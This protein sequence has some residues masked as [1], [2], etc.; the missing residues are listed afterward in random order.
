MRRQ[1]GAG[2]NQLEYRL[3][4]VVALTGFSKQVLH[5]WEHRYPAMSPQR[6]RISP[7]RYSDTEVHRLQLLKTCIEGGYKIGQLAALEVNELKR[8]SRAC[9]PAVQVP[10]DELLHA[11]QSMDAGFL[12]TRLA[13]LFATLG[14]VRFA[15]TVVDPLMTEVGA[16]WNSGELTIAAEHCVTAIVRNVLGQALRQ[17]STSPSNALAVFT[18]PEDELHEMGALTAAAVAQTSGLRTIYLGSQL[19]AAQ[20][21]DTAKALGASVV[22]LSF[23]TVSNSL[24]ETYLEDVPRNLSPEVEIWLGGRA[25]PEVCKKLPERASCFEDMPDYLAAIRR[26]CV[27]TALR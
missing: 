7:R 22:G 1:A 4:D 26:H 24:V 21:A 23:S 12:E 14:T 13:T 11:A 2:A 5:A 9:D 20:L 18:T 10:L 25:C 8:L 19:S 16:L 6:D 15:E 17:P 3:R 27:R